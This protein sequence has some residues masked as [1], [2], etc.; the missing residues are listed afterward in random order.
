MRPEARVRWR[1]ILAGPVTI[2]CRHRQSSCEGNIL[3]QT[4]TTYVE[5]LPDTVSY[6]LENHLDT[7]IDTVGEH[8][9]TDSHHLRE[10]VDTDSH[11]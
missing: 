3:T 4:V 11:Y 2:Y 5:P 8:L 7:E 6:N 1:S 10:H 9:Y